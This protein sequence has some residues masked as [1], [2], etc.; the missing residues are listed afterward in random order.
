MLPML[1]LRILASTQWLEGD[2]TNRK[3]S[4]RRREDSFEVGIKEVGSTTWYM[5][6]LA[7]NPSVWL[8][9]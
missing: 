3:V 7:Q 9:P 4:P 2:E 5:G 8:F 1:E 6:L